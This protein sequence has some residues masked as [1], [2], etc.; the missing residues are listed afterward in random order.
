MDTDALKF[1]G[2]DSVECLSDFSMVSSFDELGPNPL[3]VPHE[4]VSSRLQA[5]LLIVVLKYSEDFSLFAQR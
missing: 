4:G 1:A 2:D 3:G 5:L